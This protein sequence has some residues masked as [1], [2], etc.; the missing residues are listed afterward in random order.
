MPKEKKKTWHVGQTCLDR[1]ILQ[2]FNK[3]YLHAKNSPREKKEV[4]YNEFIVFKNLVRK[5]M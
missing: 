5:D 4:K 2:S 1:N 3:V